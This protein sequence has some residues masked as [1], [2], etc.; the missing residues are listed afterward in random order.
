MVGGRPG[1][2]RVPYAVLARLLR[3]A[4]RTEDVIR[5]DDGLDDF[6]KSELARVLPE[7][8]AAPVGPLVEARFRSAVMQAL[9]AR[10]AAGLAGFAVDDLHFADDAT[11]ELLPQLVIPDLRWIGAV[12][13]AECPAPIAAW[14]RAEGGQRLAEVLLAPLSESAVRELLESLALP[15]IDAAALAGALARHTGGNPFFVLETLNALVETGDADPASN[16]LPTPRSVGALIERRLAQL[17]APC[18]KD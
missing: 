8:G 7:L 12:R 3:A 2:T 13:G 16:R 15:G 4:L 17:S 18:T 5:L 11:L 14:Q 6:V 10:Q 1:D 9:S